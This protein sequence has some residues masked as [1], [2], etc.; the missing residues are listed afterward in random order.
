MSWPLT[1]FVALLSA[2]VGA[3]AGGFTAQLAV[4]WYRISSFEGGS[5]YFV[6]AMGLAGLLGGLLIGLVAS[7]FVAHGA[8][9][10][11]L[12]AF[13]LSLA[14]VLGIVGSIG[15]VARLLADVAPTLGGEPLMLLVEV[16]W[17]D[18]PSVSPATD[19]TE[20]R[21]RLTSLA[22]SVAR[23][24]RT[25][26]F[27]TE[28]ARQEDGRWIVPGAV[29]VFT[30]RGK[31]VID[32]EPEIPN[33]AGI[34][35]PLPAYPRS[36]QL[37]WSGWMPQ[38]RA[39][40][41]PLPDGFRYRY[42]VVPRNQP[43]RSQAYGP[44]EISTIARSFYDFS[45]GNAASTIGASAE[46]LVRHRGH[47]VMIESVGGDDDRTAARFERVSAVAT[48][49]GPTPALL[50]QVSPPADNE[51]CFLLKDVTERLVIEAVGDCPAVIQAHPL[52]GDTVR[53]RAAQTRHAVPG[54]IDRG[55]FTGDSASGLFLLVHAVLDTR[56]LSV[57]RIPMRDAPSL[58][59]D[60]PPLGVAPDEQ[61]FVRVGFGGD[62]GQAD[63]LVVTSIGTGESYSVPI[64]RQR[65]RMGPEAAIDPAWVS[66][67]FAWE[68]KTGPGGIDRLVT[69]PNVVPLAYRGRLTL[70]RDGYRE[71]RLEPAGQP[72]FDALVDFLKAEFKATRTA[73]DESSY[74]FQVHIDG[75]VVHVMLIEDSHQVSVF[76]NRG[77]DS[78]IVAAIAQRFDSA[79]ATGKYDKL[80]GY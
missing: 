11:F 53:F 70:D 37:E 22:G 13:G 3:I 66:H 21:L 44:F 58:R 51:R 2:V 74:G 5:G 80:F 23:T 57:R 64:D 73:E 18:G 43:V 72:L 79:L 40:T 9:P 78:E 55:M 4:D 15:G 54:R 65:T 46:F 63:V 47:P 27:W 52:T 59:G 62:D 8:H 24:S 25:G 17:P 26:P 77:T 10:G 28:D 61:S 32:V 14:V 16:R 19:T 6:V 50:V 30:S 71:Y 1:I 75:Q 67:Y 60:V 56:D 69:R 35:V 29:E 41:A 42:K 48:I 12:R 36:A 45:W 49:D 20:R 33:A 31:R 76:M 39:G 38:A 34:L 68:K 7:R